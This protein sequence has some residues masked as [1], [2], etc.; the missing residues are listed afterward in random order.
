M[1]RRWA[2]GLRPRLLAALVFT[3][4]VTLGVAA[5]ALLPPLQDKLTQQARS[6]L[7]NA[8]GADTKFFEQQIERAF[9]P[10]AQDGTTDRDAW[11]SALRYG[12]F[13]LSSRASTLRE[14]TGARVIVLDSI[15]GDQPIVDT[16]FAFSP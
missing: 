7:E 15:P 8:T 13:N 6:D 3:A 9:K 11:L 10:L 12:Q 1:R 16:D 4:A 14:R 5:L 2:F